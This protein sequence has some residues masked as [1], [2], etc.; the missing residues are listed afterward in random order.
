MGDAAH[1][2][3]NHMAQGAAT[4]M[5]DGAFLAQC[6]AAAVR[7]RISLR[8]AIA[9]YETERMPK[10]HAKQQVSF[11]NGAV[12]HLPDG[13]GQQARDEAMRPELEGKFLVRSSNLYDDPLTVWEV[14]GYDV[15]GH[16]VDAVEKFLNA[17]CEPMHPDTKVTAGMQAQYMDWFLSDDA[18]RGGRVVKL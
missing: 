18:K 16:A 13:P 2:M 12:W 7:N 10:A 14:Y 8:E 6:V 15:E 11:L 17:G 5:E 3:V 4:S 9:I 1:A